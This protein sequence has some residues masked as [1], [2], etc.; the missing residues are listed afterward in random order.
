MPA[1]RS[2]KTS[3]TRAA[4]RP[5]ALHFSEADG[6]RHLHVGGSA[7][8]SAM[9][10]DA[11]DELA[12]AYTRA[13]MAALLFQP[14]PRDA[15][16]IGLG[17]GSMAKWLYRHLPRMRTVAV[18]V[19]FRVVGAAHRVFGLPLGRKR[20]R[21][22]VG[23][24]ADYVAAHPAS[25][26]LV[27]LDAFVNHRQAPS[28]R[29]AEFYRAAR[30]A[31][32]RDGVL[33]INFMT[34]DP[35]LRAYLRRLAEAF[36]GRLACLRAIGEDNVVVFAFA[37][38]PG[39]I[40][41]TSLVGRAIALQREHGLEFRTFAQNVRPPWRILADRRPLLAKSELAVWR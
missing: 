2:S 24:G 38:D 20:L 9:R 28:I 17:G 22:L 41:P 1:K 3:A 37:D 11:P 40:T 32:R 21:V 4:A 34:D 16:L 13:M 19:D 23:D 26:D 5:P 8:Q 27:F 31:L 30:A 39:V 12:L 15:I 18:E 6:L 35:G 7:I 33:A 36:E 10:I 14:A 29:T 25:A